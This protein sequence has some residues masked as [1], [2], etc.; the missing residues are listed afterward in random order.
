MVSLI[1]KL[2]RKVDRKRG[3]FGPNHI[4]HKEYCFIAT[5]FHDKELYYV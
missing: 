5:I 2:Y 4:S 1:I 3:M